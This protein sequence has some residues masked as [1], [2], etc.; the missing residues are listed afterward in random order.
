MFCT[1][2]EKYIFYLFSVSAWWKW[3]TVVKS[4]ETMWKVNSSTHLMWNKQN[5]SLSLFTWR[6]WLYFFHEKSEVVCFC[7]E[8]TVTACMWIL[9]C[10]TFWTDVLSSAR[11]VARF[12]AHWPSCMAAA[13]SVT[14][15]TDDFAEVTILLPGCKMK[16]FYSIKTIG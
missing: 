12:L 2:I 1:C 4:D 14:V 15:G 7:T 10:F 5:I 6:L 13:W 3:W 11:Q 8:N 9:R 16:C